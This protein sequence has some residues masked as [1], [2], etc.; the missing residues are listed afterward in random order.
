MTSR[1]LCLFD[2]DGTLT[3]PR[4]V[5]TP[6]MYDF[7][8]EL[9]KK[10]PVGLVGGS[11]LDK[12]SEQMGGRAA[13]HRFK[14]VFAE[15]GLV[16]YEYDQ[17]IGTMDIASH[18]GED[19]LQR[20]INFILRYLSY[21]QLPLKRGTFV[22]FR[23]GMLNVSPIGRSCSQV[24]RDAFFEYDKVHKI[25]EKMVDVLRKE[26]ADCDLQFSIGGQISVDIF[27]KGWDKS[28]CLS[29]LK[30]YNKIHFFGD[31]T[32]EGGNDYEIFMDPRTIGHAVT[33]PEDTM[34]QL[35]E[36]FFA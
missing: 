19:L 8:C 10:V 1:T 21:V 22:E 32:A 20:L 27:P 34:K 23:K 15:N 14:H 16:A 28:F 12:I 36:L 24:E 17:L 5:I 13:L 9:D 4:Q 18:L 26:F 30:C 33:S 7:L 25:R 11:D 31:K 3:K 35:K 6:E 29:Y 2:V